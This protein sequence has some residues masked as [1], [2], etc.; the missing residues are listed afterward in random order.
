MLGRWWRSDRRGGGAGRVSIKWKVYVACVWGRGGAVCWG[1]GEGK[2]KVSNR[3]RSIP[4]GHSTTSSSLLRISA[5]PPPAYPS[6]PARF[7]KD[8]KDLSSLQDSAI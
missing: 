4:E 8:F 2:G 3:A 7:P 5:P 6:P 1:E